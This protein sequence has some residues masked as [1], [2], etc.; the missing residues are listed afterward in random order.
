MMLTHRTWIAVNGTG[1]PARLAAMI[2]PMAP[3]LVVS[4]KRTNLTMLS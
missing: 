1:R 3:M 4:W 2:V